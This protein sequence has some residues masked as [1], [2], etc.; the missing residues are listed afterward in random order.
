MHFIH[1]NTKCGQ[2]Y[3]QAVG[4]CETADALTVLGIL[5]EEAKWSD[6][7]NFEHIVEGNFSP[8]VLKL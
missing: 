4:N 5:I 3:E 1:Y 8:Y 6:N 7:D 2:S